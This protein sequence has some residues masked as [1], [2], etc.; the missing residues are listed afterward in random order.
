MLKTTKSGRIE[1]PAP[2]A[3]LSSSREL[4]PAQWQQAQA[5]ANI[6]TNYQRPCEELVKKMRAKAARRGHPT[7]TTSVLPPSQ[8]T[9][10]AALSS[11]PPPTQTSSSVP[12]TP[13]QAVSIAPVPP[14]AR[15]WEEIAKDG[16]TAK[17][18]SLNRPWDRKTWKMKSNNNQRLKLLKDDGYDI[19][20][21]QIKGTSADQIVDAI[22]SHLR[23]RSQRTATPIHSACMNVAPL[24]AAI[25]AT[26]KDK[27]ATSV[28][29]ANEKSLLQSAQKPV[30]PLAERG[31]LKE[32]LFVTS[33]L[34]GY[35]RKHSHADD[36][37]PDWHE[38]K[39]QKKLHATYNEAKARRVVEPPCTC[40][41]WEKLVRIWTP[42]AVSKAI[43]VQ[44]F[45]L[46]KRRAARDIFSSSRA[47]RKVPQ[48]RP[49][50]MEDP[51]HVSEPFFAPKPPS[52]PSRIVFEP[53]SPPA[54]EPTGSDVYMSAGG[55]C[56]M[57]NEMKKLAYG[58]DEAGNFLILDSEEVE[59][60]EGDKLMEHAGPEEDTY[61]YCISISSTAEHPM[62]VQGDTRALIGLLK[63]L[64]ENELTH[65]TE[66]YW[67]AEKM[68]V[69]RDAWG[70][71]AGEDKAV[72]HNG[73]PYYLSDAT[74]DALEKMEKVLEAG[75]DE[76]GVEVSIGHMDSR[77]GF[78]YG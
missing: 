3:R 26:L 9:S 41:M 2:K 56:L 67:D 31:I 44:A 43:E 35:K 58:Q 63:H 8:P 54:H 74:M 37:Q 76:G 34:A 48:A 5:L 7:T 12:F 40:C 14:P 27:V 28:N 20:H 29:G 61:R 25:S 21:L 23:A 33:Q 10:L 32:E 71:G 51:L 73:V 57:I 46:V 15:S 11:A 22:F 30:F 78:T 1:K 59:D 69:R 53:P 62:V 77:K 19:G 24:P 72:R 66:W 6:T 36:D 68:D 70:W 65:I 47:A 39:P 45:D 17:R 50:P 60:L 52:K 38:A 55:V 42:E 16:I 64:R 13:S 75:Q 18:L 49:T 4:T